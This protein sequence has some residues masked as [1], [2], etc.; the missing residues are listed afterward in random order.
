MIFGHFGAG[1]RGDELRAVLGDAAGLVALTDHEARDVL[2]EEQRHAALRAEL[3]E[4]RALERAVGKEHAVVGENADQHPREPGEA[5][6]ER[7]PV[8]RLEGVELR[9]VDEARDDLVRVDLL[10]QIERRDPHQLLGRIERLDRLH[11]FDRAL[12]RAIEVA[13]RAARQRQRVR[14]VARERVGDAR[15]AGVQI[16]AAEVLGADR[17]A[18]RGFHQR[19]PG[20]KDRALL[21]DDDRLVRHRRNIGAARGAGAHDH[22]DLGDSGR[23]HARL[24]VEDAAEVLAV[25]KHLGL[26]RQIGAA[27]IDQ[28]DA[29]QTVLR[30]D[31][32]R[33]QM[34]LHRHRIV[35]AALDGRVVGDDH[36]LA[37]MR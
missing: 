31:F 9:A 17:L 10:A 26:V 32:L 14:V 35:G 1:D 11:P 5:G 22:G 19:R 2:Q 27:G 15:H 30:R 34:L 33:P 21:L 16:A 29:G 23:G 36:R 28:I 25:R 20:E 8:A 18:G 37:A 24:I 6:D 13:D 7:R 3:D 12:R 4:M